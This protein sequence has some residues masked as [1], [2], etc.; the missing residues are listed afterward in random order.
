MEA[1]SLSGEHRLP[2]CRSRQL[3]ETISSEMRFAAR[4]VAGKL[5]AT[6]GWQPV[7]PNHSMRREFYASLQLV[8]PNAVR[9]LSKNPSV[10]LGKLRDHMR[11]ER[12]FVVLSD[13]G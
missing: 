3:A 5:P 1:S 10:T 12:S 7:L 4:D 8:I 6:T 11:V 13:W 9:D 2:A